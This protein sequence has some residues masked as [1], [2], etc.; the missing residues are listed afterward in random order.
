MAIVQYAFPEHIKNVSLGP[1]HP[2]S[3]E[4]LRKHAG[5]DHFDASD[6]RKRHPD[7]RIGSDPSLANP[8]D[9]QRLLETAAAELLED[10][11][12]LLEE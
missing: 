10:Y 12:A 5:D 2:I 3:A 7:G 9:G 1:W 4:Y 8:E 11:L 6:H